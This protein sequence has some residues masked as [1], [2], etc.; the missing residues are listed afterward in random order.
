M[1]QQVGTQF[2]LET[3]EP[4]WLL[5]HDETN[6]FA[7]PREIP[8]GVTWAGRPCSTFGSEFEAMEFIETNNL[9]F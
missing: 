3:T 8:V 9:T 5:L 4:R 6:Y 7:M 1:I 2:R